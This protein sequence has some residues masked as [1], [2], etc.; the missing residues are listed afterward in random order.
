MKPVALLP[1]IAIFCVALLSGACENQPVPYVRQLSGTWLWESTCGAGDKPCIYP[2][3]TNRKSL[4]FVDG[5]F[6]ETTNGAVTKMQYFYITDE[7]LPIPADPYIQVIDILL[8]DGTEFSVALV[9]NESRLFIKNKADES[10]IDY[11]RGGL[12]W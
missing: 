4:S 1:L 10:L 12:A 9:R 2:D 3:G 6:K 8:R 7:S 5:V 11:Y